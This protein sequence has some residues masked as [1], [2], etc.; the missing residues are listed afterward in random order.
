MAKS[1]GHLREVLK[2]KGVTFSS[3]ETFHAG[4]VGRWM[5]GIH[6]RRTLFV[7]SYERIPLACAKGSGN[8][9]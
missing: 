2:A 5:K 1:E 6:A 3:V 4:M 8:D 9:Q 7:N